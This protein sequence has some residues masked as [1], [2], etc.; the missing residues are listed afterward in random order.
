MASGYDVAGPDA[1]AAWGGGTTMGGYEDRGVGTPAQLAAMAA[2]K[3][4][5]AQAAA[6]QA[7]NDK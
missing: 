2:A 5:I 1:A 7:A 3:E 6:V 4:E